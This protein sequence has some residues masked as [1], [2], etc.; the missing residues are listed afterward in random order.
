V[1]DE[2]Q[3]LK[4]AAVRSGT[5]HELMPDVLRNLS[6]GECLKAQEIIEETLLW[7]KQRERVWRARD[8]RLIAIKDMDSE[9]LLNVQSYLESKH[10]QRRHSAWIK[11]CVDAEVRH[12]SAK[13]DHYDLGED[14][15]KR[16]R[17]KRGRHAKKKAES[18]AS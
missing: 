17:K 18:Q 4:R 16:R 14:G 15:K 8:G 10:G 5:L 3:R 12:R 1:D 9:H 2:L 7:H 13:P 6:V 11:A